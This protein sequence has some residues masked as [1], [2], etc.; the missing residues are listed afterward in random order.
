MKPRKKI[1]WGSF[2]EGMRNNGIA[3]I[4]YFK[5][6]EVKT[7]FPRIPLFISEEL[8]KDYYLNAAKNTLKCRRKSPDVGP[9]LVQACPAWA[10]AKGFKSP[11]GPHGGNC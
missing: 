10:S 7:H 3:A 5:L 1:N 6:E 11:A 2:L 8:K 9:G 4:V